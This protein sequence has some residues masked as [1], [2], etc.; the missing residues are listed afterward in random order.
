MLPHRKNKHQMPRRHRNRRLNR[1]KNWQPA[2]QANES[3]IKQNHIIR[4]RRKR[5]RNYIV[6]AKH[7]TTIPSE[8]NALRCIIIHCVQRTQNY[9]LLTGLFLVVVVLD[10]M[11]AV[12]CAT[13]GS[14][15][16]VLASPKMSRKKCLNSFAA[17]ASMHVI[18]KNCFV[19]AV[20]RTMSHNFTYAATSARTGSTD[21][22]SAYYKVKPKAL[23]STSV[24]IVSAT[25][26]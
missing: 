20:N 21:V 8:L 19:Y 6:F 14:M 15:A 17:N 16:N 2:A 13:I 12:I 7:H 5:R 22:A 18:H 26:L 3:R 11:L 24:P 10:S 4:Q 9:I 23:M 25:I 1:R